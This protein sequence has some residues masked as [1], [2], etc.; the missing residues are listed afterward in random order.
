VESSALAGTDCA[1][2]F[3]PIVEPLSENDNSVMA[4]LP[5]EAA[6]TNSRGETLSRLL[7]LAKSARERF[8]MDSWEVGVNA[9]N[10]GHTDHQGNAY[11]TRALKPLYEWFKSPISVEYPQVLEVLLRGPTL[12]SSRAAWVYFHHQVTGLISYHES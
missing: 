5:W 2:I 8:G 3:S 9:E 7:G 12:M 11:A 1:D 6:M 10:S 4:V